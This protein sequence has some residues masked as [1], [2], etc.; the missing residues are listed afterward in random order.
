MGNVLLVTD[1]GVSGQPRGRPR[2]SPSPFLISIGRPKGSTCASRHLLSIRV[3]DSAL[4]SRNN[5][6]CKFNRPSSRFLPIDSSLRKQRRI[7]DGCFAALTF[8]AVQADVEFV[9]GEQTA[10]VHVI[11]HFYGYQSK[12]WNL[13]KTFILTVKFSNEYFV[14]E[15]T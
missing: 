1:R 2:G 4:V 15:F 14:M 3:N 10:Y 5:Y 13:P 12:M 11:L 9:V 8:Q 6:R 7:Y